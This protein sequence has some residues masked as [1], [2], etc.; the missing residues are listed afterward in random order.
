VGAQCER[1]R[2]RRK[3]WWMNEERIRKR[4]GVNGVFGNS[5]PRLFSFL[6]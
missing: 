4:D 5:I 1:E 2:E 3:G 6:L